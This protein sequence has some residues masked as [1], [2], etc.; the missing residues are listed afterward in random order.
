MAKVH[1]PHRPLME[2]SFENSLMRRYLAKE[3]HESVTLD[4]MESDRGWRVSGIGRLSYTA[5][6]ART[7]SRS[8]QLRIPMRDEDYLRAHVR[9]G[10][11]VCNQG[12]SV[13][14]TLDFR[15][16]RDW[17]AHNRISLWVY[18]HP[19]LMHSYAFHL[20][21]DCEGSV[22]GPVTPLAVHFVQDLEPGRWNHIVWEIPDLQR[23]KVRSF[24]I[25]QLLR[26]HG[27]EEGGIV[28]YNIDRIDLERVDCEGYEGWEVAPGKVAFHHLGHR[29]SGPKVAFVADTGAEEFEL[30]AARSGETVAR[31][32]VKHVSNDRGRFAELDFSAFTRPGRYLLRCGDSASRAFDITEDLWYG[33]IGKAL[34]F[35]YGQR[36][37]FPV[38]G[39]HGI[40]HADLRGRRGDTM[41]VINGGWHDAGDLSQGSFRTAPSVYGML[42]IYDELRRRD[43]QPELQERL[44]EEA[45]WGLDWLL[46]TRFGDGYRITWFT[47]HVYTDNEIGTIDDT[48]AKARHVA[49]E[50]FLFAAVAAH[51]GRVLAD[52]DPDRAAQS[53]AAA[54][55]DYQA[56]LKARS[57]WLQATRDEAAYAA[58]AAVELYRATGEARYS[59]EAAQF[60]RLLLQCQEQH[61]VDGIPIAGYFYRDTSR[62]QVVHDHHMSF[63][64]SP[65][66][67]LEALCDA[68]PDHEDWTEWYGAAIVYSEYFL[69]RGTSASSPYDLLPNS[70]WSRREI[71]AMAERWRAE[72][73]DSEPLIRQYEDGAPL[74]DGHRLRVFPI[75]VNNRQ[76]GNTGVHLSGTVAL[77]AAARLRND[78]RLQDLAGRQLQWVFGGN[79]FSQCLMYGEGYDFQPL[80]AYCLRNLVGALP[81]GMDCMADDAPWWTCFNDSDYKEIWVV[82]GARFLEN[83]AYLSAP[84]RVEGTTP[85][86][87]TFT[88]SRTGVET[89]VSGRFALNLAPGAYTVECGSMNRRL[90][91]LAGSSY[92]LA[93]D[94]QH[95]I[96]VD[97]SASE[98]KGEG[99][100]RVEALVRGAGEH[101]LEVRLF[102]ATSD[103]LELHVDLTAGLEQAVAWDLQVEAPEKPW[104]LVVIPDGDFAGRR[105]TFGRLP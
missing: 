12:G 74:G 18:V 102:N 101:G 80:F 81:V 20:S 47:A 103:D 42:R 16:P 60:G 88:E 28:T 5:E 72:D 78:R 79:P 87:A 56:T 15:P 55:E 19:G 26:G 76:H 89:T 43:V 86:K 99:R 90:D 64:D 68:L 10:S 70:V 82:P 73:R 27:P 22:A 6:I 100:V 84:A 33:T 57:D 62:Q 3:V 93:L 36:C 4:D 25:G 66:L 65:L 104:A 94:P 13:S 46:S 48:I 61:F 50:N 9:D 11:L 52:A 21:F 83:M 41:K 85:S 2:A 53:L 1:F 39:V 105:E 96:E 51:A 98:T 29:P 32:P 59:E 45:C 58:L 8:M 37:G 71:E 69:A 54:A 31:F 30:V 40:C 91:L 67:A 92:T 38:P 75:W 34:N 63:E 77:S 7:G 49:F 44:L 17:S 35:Y 23:N 14:A 95:W 24:S 97:L